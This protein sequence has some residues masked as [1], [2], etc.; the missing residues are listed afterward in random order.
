MVCTRSK[1]S[2][3]LSSVLLLVAELR[4]VA[5]S[6]QRAP[7]T[8]VGTNYWFFND[9]PV[10]NIAGLT[11]FEAHLTDSDANNLGEGL[12]SEGSGTLRLVA[13]ERSQA[14]DA[15]TGANF[16]SFS[17][18]V[19]NDTGQLAFGG[20]SR[21]RNGPS[22]SGIWK[23]Q[24]GEQLGYVEA[25]TLDGF[26]NGIVLINDKGDIA[27]RNIGIWSTSSGTV[28]WVARFENQ[29]PGMPSGVQF[30]SLRTPVLNNSGE[31]A[32]AA[33][34]T[35]I[36][37]R[38]TLD[39]VW[40]G[41]PGN[42]ELVAQ[43]GSPVPGITNGV[44]FE[45]FTDSVVLNSS[46]Q[47]AFGAFLTGSGVDSDNKRGVWSEGSGS[48]DLIA[49]SGSSAPG[50]ETDVE[51]SGFGSPLLNDAGLTAFTASLIGDSVDVTNGRGIWSETAGNLDLIVRSGN[52]A[53][54]TPSGANFE[55]FGTPALNA[56]GQLAFIA[57]L[58]IPRQIERDGPII[59]DPNSG[60]DSTNDDGLW[61]TD[62]E[63]TL[64]LIA[65]EGDLLEVGPNDFRT[66]LSLDFEAN[67]GN[68]DGR[69][70]GFNNRGQI[71]FAASFREGGSGVFV[72]NL[73]TVPEP[74]TLLLILSGVVLSVLS[75]QA[76][77][78]TRR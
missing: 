69:P 46:G 27:S 29:A 59:G 67:T 34:V 49:R 18:P 31:L 50:T 26:S 65:R 13:R 5:L 2:F 28:D 23:E 3:A 43:A 42:L 61:A 51:F 76:D 58:F 32:F 44:E 33:S 53:P 66:I 14:P 47:T 48:L 54:G 21:V 6:G 55:D 12:W 24:L 15:P 57:G 16:V 37:T 7:G 56:N 35:G 10:L 22:F 41:S 17:T 36:G 25:V 68:G 73:V 4:T 74:S 45:Q 71:A 77:R 75:T 9:P 39:G 78:R 38:F 70:S 63:G 11:A 30:N 72:S 8:P 19:L 1:F 52:Q 60:V 62:I 20:H 64:H 40:S